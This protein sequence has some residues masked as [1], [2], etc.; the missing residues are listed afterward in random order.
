MLDSGLPRRSLGS[1]GG[2]CGASGDEI[3]S[4]AGELGIGVRARSLQEAAQALMV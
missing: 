2:W 3:P 4:M 1:R